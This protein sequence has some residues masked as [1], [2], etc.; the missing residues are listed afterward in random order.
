MV[1][2]MLTALNVLWTKAVHLLG[3][4]SGSELA[5]R[6]LGCLLIVVVVGFGKQMMACRRPGLSDMLMLGFVLVVV[7][8]LHQNNYQKRQ[9]QHHHQH[10]HPRSPWNT[11]PSAP[12]CSPNNDRPHRITVYEE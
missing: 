12:N 7:A 3:L 8:V 5:W 11:V 1:V 10:Q 9:N 2:M 6:C 4:A